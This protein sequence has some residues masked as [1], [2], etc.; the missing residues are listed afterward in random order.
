MLISIVLLFLS[1]FSHFLCVV[2]IIP[3]LYLSHIYKIKNESQTNTFTYV[4]WLFSALFLL[5]ILLMLYEYHTDRDLYKLYPTSKYLNIVSGLFILFLF[6]TTFFPLQYFEINSLLSIPIALVIFFILFMLAFYY[7]K[8]SKTLSLLSSFIAIAGIIIFPVFQILDLSMCNSSY[9]LILSITILFYFIAQNVYEKNT[10]IFR[11]LSLFF[12]IILSTLSIFSFQLTYELRDPERLWLT[13]AGNYTSN[14]EA[15]KYLAR[16]LT[17]KAEEETSEKT[18]YLEKSEQAW[19]TLLE[20]NPENVEALRSKSILCLERNQY[21]EAK[22]YIAKAIGLNPFDCENIKMQIKIIENETKT[23]PE[24]RDN[25]IQLYNAYISLYLI[26]KNL[27]TE[28]KN[29]FLEIAQNLLNY[30][31][32]WEILKKDFNTSGEKKEIFQKGYDDIQKVL[33]NIPAT[34]LVSGDTFNAPYQMIADYYEKKGILTLSQSWLSFGLQKEQNNKDLLIKLGVI[35]GKLGKSNEFIEKWRNYF[36][37][38]KQLWED[39]VQECVKSSNFISAQT[40]MEQTSYSIGEKY[41]ILSRIAI[42]KGY[43]EQA[44]LWLEKAKENNPTPEEQREINELINK[45]Q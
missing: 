1:T 5:F 10:T 33:N 20:L 18:D 38:N 21:D 36:S 2:L 28:E 19:D 32:G 9:F 39:L 30:E 4:H 11:L 16:T 37:D 35:Y 6:P 12:L 40:Y 41:I 43:R 17:R 42:E 13:C 29:K 45:I 31:Q 44:K 23:K 25:L 24:D 26:N 15:W 27:N 3:I 7:Y 34:L 22:R 14:I 8:N